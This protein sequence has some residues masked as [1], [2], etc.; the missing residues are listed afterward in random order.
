M[1]GI[2]SPIAPQHDFVIG[3]AGLFG[4]TLAERLASA[5]YG[6]LVVE[7]RSELGGLCASRRD[8]TTGVEYNPFGTHIFATNRQEVWSYL[9]RF[10]EF[11]AYQH[12]LYSRYRDALVPVPIGLEAI[13]ACY[14]RDMDVEEAQA[15]VARDA[16][17]FRKPRYRTAEEAALGTM[18]PRLYESFV[19]GYVEKQ[20]GQAAATL[21]PEVLT[22]RFRLRLD[23]AAKPPWSARW[24]GLP[25]EGYAA[26]FARMA[27]TSGVEVA[28]NADITTSTPA[29]AAFV[30]RIFTGPIDELLHGRFGR[31]ERR[32][33]SI[34][35]RIED[36][37]SSQGAPVVSHPS[38]DVPYYRT[39]EPALLPWR[40][41]VRP[42]NAVLVGYEYG[43]GGGDY[44]VEFMLR[45]SSNMERLRRY[46]EAA[47]RIRGWVAGGR[48]TTPYANMSQTIERA[49]AC[50]RMLLSRT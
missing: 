35:W 45:S 13:C 27:A 23:P 33:L 20:W 7:R 43:S 8:G 31:L 28:L 21:A 42:R 12:V 29:F 19:R 49:L 25:S 44:E 3:G 5:G 16:T 34:T 4:L 24:Q 2:L 32:K 9:S 1:E 46:Q 40:R 18:G 6:V 26:M 38:A 39:H 10:T 15:L 47:S 17:P 50:A 48:G 37:R 14:G 41:I 36:D 22:E 30:A 11:V